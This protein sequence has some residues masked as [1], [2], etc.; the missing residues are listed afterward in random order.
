MRLIG[1]LRNEVIAR[2]GRQAYLRIINKALENFGLVFDHDIHDV[3]KRQRNIF[4]C[5]VASFE[6]LDL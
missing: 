1:D 4:T 2:I 6:D 3:S 5:V